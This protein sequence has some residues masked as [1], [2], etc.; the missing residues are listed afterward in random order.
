MDKLSIAVNEF[1]DDQN[2]MSIGQLKA[3]LNDVNVKQQM[4]NSTHTLYR[5]ARI[6]LPMVDLIRHLERRETKLRDTLE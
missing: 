1:D 6:Y 4:A 2:S 5:Y 3:L